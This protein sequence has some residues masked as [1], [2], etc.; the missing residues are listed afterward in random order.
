MTLTLQYGSFLHFDDIEEAA[1]VFENK[2]VS[3][4]FLFVHTR[5]IA[6]EKAAMQ[7]FVRDDSCIAAHVTVFSRRKILLLGN[8]SMKRVF[9][10]GG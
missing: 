4:Q 8:Y 5:R 7:D 3:Q 1:D 6:T 9:T 10:S 2:K